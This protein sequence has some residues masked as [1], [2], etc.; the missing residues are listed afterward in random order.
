M[1][2]DQS[3]LRCVPEAMPNDPSI[4]NPINTVLGTIWTFQQVGVGLPEHTHT[5]GNT[6]C[7][8]VMSGSVAV[9]Q[10]GTTVT[11]PAGD[12]IDLGT[13][14]HSIMALEPSV[15]INITKNGVTPESLQSKVVELD[16]VIALA[17]SLKTSLANLAG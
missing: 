11:R 5:D 17:T 3:L 13:T 2:I 4:P 10:D 7:T 15:I 6:H 8:I 14:P 9:T 1:T 12:I 16:G